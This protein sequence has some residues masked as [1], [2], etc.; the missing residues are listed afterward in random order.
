VLDDERKRAEE[1][2]QETS[3]PQGSVYLVRLD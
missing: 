3:T 1:V 2:A